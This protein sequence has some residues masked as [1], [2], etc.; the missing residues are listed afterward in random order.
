M[1]ARAL[2][3]TLVCASVLWP[4]QVLACINAMDGTLRGFH[5]SFGT[6][7]GLWTVGAVFLNRVVLFNNDGPPSQQVHKVSW[8]RRAFFLLVSAAFIL[9]LAAVMAGGPILTISAEDIARC[10]VSLP[11]LLALVASPA[12]LFSLQ[13]AFFQGPGRRLFRKTRWGALVGVVVSSLFLV[14]GLGMARDT[15]ILPKLCK[16]GPT[17]LDPELVY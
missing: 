6:D 4:L 3:S 8:A 9:V 17:I 12:L 1:L 14:I 11:F 2:A 13:S 10:S 5:E 7:L 15:Y 16:A